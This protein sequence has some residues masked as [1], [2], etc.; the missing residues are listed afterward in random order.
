MPAR[1]DGG[2]RGA[3][4]DY[5]ECQPHITISYDGDAPELG[6]VEPYQGE[7]PLRPE[8][9]KEVIDDCLASVSEV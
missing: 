8:V 5:A 2:E 3:S 9:L 6:T 4:W 1:G 7:I